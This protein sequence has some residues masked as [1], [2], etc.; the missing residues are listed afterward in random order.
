MTV[1]ASP[2]HIADSVIRDFTSFTTQVRYTDVGDAAVSAAK[3]CLV[4]AL[5]CALGAQ[6][7]DVMRALRTVASTATSS[8][9]A[10]VFGT[11]IRTTPDLAAFVNG[12]AIRCLDFNDDYFG[13]DES[14]AKGDTG[15]HPSDNLGG[16]LAAAQVSGATGADALLG[17]IIAYEVCGQLVDEVV[18]RGNGWDHPTFHSIATSAAA[19]RLLGLSRAQT[20]DAIRIAS[21]ANIC[22]FETRVGSISNWK[23]LAGPNGSRNG[24]FAAMLAEAGITGP[25]MAF[26]GARGFMRQLDHRFSLGPFGG[27]GRP[28]RVENTYFKHLPLRYEL[29]LPVQLA[30]KLREVVDPREIASLKVYLE[31]KSVASREAEPALWRPSGRET[32]DHSGPYLIAAALVDGGITEATFEPGRYLDPKLLS[33][34]DTI[35]LIEDT[36]Y[37]ASFPWQ[38]ACRFEVRT[39]DGRSLTIR[40]E[41]PK[42][43]PQNPM[44]DA[45]LTAK[46]LGQVE[47]RL[48]EDR[49]RELL[50]ALW[51]LEHESSLDRLFNLMT[52]GR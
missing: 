5:G 48:G 38:M 18:L 34:T 9:A 33:V 20:A 6:E 11:T 47:P 12:S 13:T 32:A 3:R 31:H 43:H 27:K 52:P 7:T 41:N 42:G 8:R 25:E 21:V 29:Q 44:S 4:D 51:S 39:E 28:F 24:L 23:G 15:P 19:A 37:T 50:R 49:A 46:F 1:A 14:N 36:T 45:E 35:E 26:E 22:L 10:T 16:V 2:N 30:L 17:V 40:G